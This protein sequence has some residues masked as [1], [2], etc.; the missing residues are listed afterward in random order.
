MLQKVVYEVTRPLKCYETTETQ[1]YEF[2]TT[3][4]SVMLEFRDK[5]VDFTQLFTVYTMHFTTFLTKNTVRIVNMI[6]DN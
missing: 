6:R 1:D 4:N 3:G 2:L 5:I